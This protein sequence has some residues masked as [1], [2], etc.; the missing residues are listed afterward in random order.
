M[1]NDER[2]E[3]E[4]KRAA[5]ALLKGCSQHFGAQV[6]RLRK[7]KAV[8]PHGRASEFEQ[9]VD[10]LQNAAD[11]ASFDSIADRLLNAFPAVH[12]WLAW[13]RRPNVARMI[14]PAFRTMESNHWESIPDT[15]NAEE[16]LHS[17]LYNAVGKDHD[18]LSGLDQLFQFANAMQAMHR[19]RQCV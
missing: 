19:A 5:E 17:A 7:T 15:T 14:F 10:S 16:S 3:E 2:S 1:S 9:L 11:P 8:I 18:M 4:L 6:T 13:W 12:N